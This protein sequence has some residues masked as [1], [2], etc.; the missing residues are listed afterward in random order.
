MGILNLSGDVLDKLQ[1][2]TG[3]GHDA[4]TGELELNVPVVDPR[5]EVHDA[6]VDLEGAGSGIE[7]GDGAIGGRPGGDGSAVG[8]A[9]AQLHG[10]GGPSEV[11]ASLIQFNLD[12]AQPLPGI[13]PLDSSQFRAW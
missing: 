6:G 4:A 8:R 1:R 5:L 9:A 11:H 2:A 12:H 13:A 3:D 7:E 10:D